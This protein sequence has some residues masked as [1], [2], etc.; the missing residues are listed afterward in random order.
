MLEGD[1]VGNRDWAMG[2][3]CDTDVSYLEALD[4]EM[5]ASNL[6]HSPA[7]CRPDTY[8]QLVDEHGEKVPT[9]CKHGFPLYQKCALCQA[10]RG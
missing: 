8:E 9:H 6:S 10:S 7:L 3:L 4:F 2:L 5:R 1:V